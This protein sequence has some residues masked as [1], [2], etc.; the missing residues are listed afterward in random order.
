MAL[1]KLRQLDYHM[2]KLRDT[3]TFWIPDSELNDSLPINSH[4]TLI[5]ATT[6][7]GNTAKPIF[8]QFI[9]FDWVS[10][11][12]KQSRMVDSPRYF[13]KHKYLQDLN[14]SPFSR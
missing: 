9:P 12:T 2:S 4:S 13:W 7:I 5:E 11:D 14:P 6:A 10:D 1:G 8:S 3:Y